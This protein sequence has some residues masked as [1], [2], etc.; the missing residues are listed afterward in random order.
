MHHGGWSGA[1]VVTAVTLEVHQLHLRQVTCNRDSC[2]R[3]K[4]AHGGHG[5]GRYISRAATCAVGSRLCLL[6]WMWLGR[7][8]TPGCWNTPFDASR[9]NHN[10]FRSLLHAWAAKLGF[11]RLSRKL[12]RK[13][14]GVGEGKILTKV[15][16]SLWK[17][18]S[19]IETLHA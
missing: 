15:A 17:T 1:I 9:L 10:E 5:A 8:R 19:R 12:F 18:S 13:L 11:P 4:C 16:A 3:S 14:R 6:R 2:G 7:Q